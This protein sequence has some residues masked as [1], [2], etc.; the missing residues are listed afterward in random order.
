MLLGHTL[1][2][3][4]AMRYEQSAE[5]EPFSVHHRFRSCNARRNYSKPAGPGHQVYIPSFG[6]HGPRKTQNFLQFNHNYSTALLFETS[7]T[8]IQT[9]QLTVRVEDDFPST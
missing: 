7:H 4:D 5:G 8:I 6:P 2:L 3:S 9:E 1:Y